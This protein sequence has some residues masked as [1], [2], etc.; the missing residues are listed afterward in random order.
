[1]KRSILKKL[2]IMPIVLLVPVNILAILMSFMNFSNNQKEL[3]SSARDSMNLIASQINQEINDMR[4]STEAYISGNAD[5]LILAESDKLDMNRTRYMK[6][7]MHVREEFS[8]LNATHQN[9]SASFLKLPYEDSWW[10]FSNYSKDVLI[11]KLKAISPDSI[12]EGKSVEIL[13]KSGESQM[14]LVIYNIDGTLYGFSYDIQN[15]LEVLKKNVPL[16]EN[17]V[18]IENS[19][20]EK[21]ESTVERFY[22]NTRI[23]VRMNLQGEVLRTKI[24][25]QVPQI[26]YILIV[27]AV[28]SIVVAPILSLFYYHQIVT[29][30]RELR[31]TF[32]EI[33]HGRRHYRAQVIGNRDTNEYVELAVYFNEMI[34]E[35]QKAKDRIYEIQLL[36]KETELNYYSQQ[37][38]PHFVLNVLNR[39]YTHTS[40][41]WA[42][43]KE[44]I[45]CLT[46]YYRYVANV[47][48]KYV[49][50]SDEMQFV[51]N[52]FCIEKMRFGN[53]FFSTV[54]WEMELEHASIPPLVITTFVENSIKHALS[55]E[56]MCSIAVTASKE[57]NSMIIMIRDTGKGFSKEILDAIHEYK[58]TGIKRSCLGIGIVNTVQRLKMLYH[59]NFQIFFFNDQGAVVEIRIPLKIY[60]G[61][62]VLEHT[63]EG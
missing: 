10:L 27:F 60:S 20:M 35:L 39:I 63:K 46:K 28:L 52:F 12:P 6:A 21:G 5:F 54:Q 19:E 36:Q 14:M 11:L 49:C 22:M 50:L 34:D 58:L 7:V 44:E 8:L 55:N 25:Q 23:G 57:R 4:L 59:D 37:I 56:K 42:V 61:S 45:L 31:K 15:V 26:T 33:R 30:T 43:A 13:S 32:H 62:D 16:L 47:K 53:H 29:P 18:I 38:R 24:L 41:E 17:A 9:V 51:K 48:Q 40:S 2:L 1:M 3:L